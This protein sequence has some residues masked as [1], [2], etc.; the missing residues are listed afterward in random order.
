MQNLM[1]IDNNILHIQNIVNNVNKKLNNINIYSFYIKKESNVF[2]TIKN[3]EVDIILIN[4]ELV[5]MDI[6]DFIY[7]E[8]LDVYKK[9]IILICKDYKLFKSLYKNEYNKYICK[10]IKYSKDITKLLEILRKIVYYKEHTSD[11]TIIQCKI[12]REL[13]KL[14]YNF[15]NIGTKYLLD[16][17]YIAKKHDVLDL[18]LSKHVYPYLSQKYK[19]SIN[20]I[21]CDIRTATQNMCKNCDENFIMEYFG[22]FE[23]S[24]P[25]VK[26]VIIA[27]L[28]K[29]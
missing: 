12:I 27:I 20:T 7:K 23:P 29:I 9:S 26:E 4:I 17:I 11:K 10:C 5:G 25:E 18:N 13:K 16:G 8:K 14:N 15:S 21:R 1:I 19:K 6:I 24:Q 3:N 22:Y 28:E 2:E